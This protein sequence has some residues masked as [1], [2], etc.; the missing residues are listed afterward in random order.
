MLL[1]SFS[2]VFNTGHGIWRRRRTTLSAACLESTAVFPSRLAVKLRKCASV[3]PSFAVVGVYINTWPRQ[4]VC[5]NVEIHPSIS[6]G[7]LKHSTSVRFEQQIEPLSRRLIT[8]QIT[9][10]M[11]VCH[12]LP[13]ELVTLFAA[14]DKD[15][16]GRISPSELRVCMKTT[17]GEEV[18]AAEA[19]ALVASV[20]ADGD[21]LLDGDEFVRLVSAAE[22]AEHDDERRR[23]LREAFG[24]YEMEGQGC[25][26]PTSLKRMLARLGSHQG[27]DDCRAM[28]CRF[29]LNGDGVL[30][31]DEFIVMMNAS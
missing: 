16:D 28:I 20:D 12:S 5:H 29:D 2:V 11:V 17:L 7:N 21:G 18:S 1:K 27:I 23:G 13:S 31:F 25:I 22:V 8:K 26:T 3:L 4:D 14:F 19:E 15:S 9:S 24:M 6:Q 30:T 10:R